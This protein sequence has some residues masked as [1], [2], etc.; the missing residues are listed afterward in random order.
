MKR[1]LI[2]TSKPV[3]TNVF[4]Y[5]AKEVVVCSVSAESPE[6]AIKSTYGSYHWG[7]ARA[8][9]GEFIYNHGRV[10]GVNIFE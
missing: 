5:S 6:E 1:Y 8:L 9:L 2:L 4:Q 3:N 7:E 10:C